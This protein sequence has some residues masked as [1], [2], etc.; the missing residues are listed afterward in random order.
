M[1]SIVLVVLLIIMEAL[2]NNMLLLVLFMILGFFLPDG[3]WLI[4]YYIKCGDISKKLY[5]SII[6]ISDNLNKVNISDAIT[7]FFLKFIISNL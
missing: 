2:P 5:Q 1:L 4:N 7:T 6:I 3:F